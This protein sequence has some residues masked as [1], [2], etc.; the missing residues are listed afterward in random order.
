MLNLS[1]VSHFW[2]RLKIYY[3]YCLNIVRGWGVIGLFVCMFMDICM[4]VCVVV[5]VYGGCILTYNRYWLPGK[6]QS[7]PDADIFTAA[8]RWPQADKIFHTKEHHKDNLLSEKW[9]T[10]RT[11]K[12]RTGREKKK[13]QTSDVVAGCSVQQHLN[14]CSDFNK[15]HIKTDIVEL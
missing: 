5:C 7:A 6:A 12:W 13:K 14:S 15:V 11:D 1:E 3:R 4:C 10:N 8:A 9:G 2:M